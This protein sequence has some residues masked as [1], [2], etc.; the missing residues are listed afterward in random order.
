M[1]WGHKIVQL[2]SSTWKKPGQRV[3]ETNLN[4]KSRTNLDRWCTRILS[5]K[6]KQSNRFV[7]RQAVYII[8]A[9]GQT[10]AVYVRKSVLPLSYLTFINLFEI[11]RIFSNLTSN[12]EK[13]SGK[14]KIFGSYARCFVFKLIL[15]R[16]QPRSHGTTIV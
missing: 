9:S 11:F 15:V 12:L 16:P 1:F 4:L 10:F 8:K 6:I 3:H 7:H 13:I 5:P 2:F 14:K